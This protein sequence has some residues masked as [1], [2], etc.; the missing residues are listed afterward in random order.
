MDKGTTG[1][2]HGC[3]DCGEERKPRI[4]AGKLTCPECGSENIVCIET[5]HE[6]TADTA[7]PALVIRCACC[8]HETTRPGQWLDPDTF[9]CSQACKSALIDKQSFDDLA[10]SGGIVD[11]P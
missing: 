10:A 5:N 8:K 1:F 9:V 6:A 4:V 11:A 2:Y 3:R 7:C